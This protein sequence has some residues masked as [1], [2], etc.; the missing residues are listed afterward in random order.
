MATN[1]KH[2]Q[3]VEGQWDELIQEPALFAGKRVR[4]AVV[5]KKPTADELRARVI[6]WLEEGKSLQYSLPKRPP[7][8]FEEYLIEKA[9]KQGLEI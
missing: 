3:E 2:V 5:H 8:P 9:R 7:T 6:R 1:G 4:I